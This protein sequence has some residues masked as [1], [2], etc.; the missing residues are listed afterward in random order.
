MLIY[1]SST[2]T[3]QKEFSSL[4]QNTDNDCIRLPGFS[5]RPVS[6]IEN[7]AFFSDLSFLKEAITQEK[8]LCGN[9][10]DFLLVFR[11][12]G[13]DY[14][15][16]LN[17]KNKKVDSEA[18]FT[19]LNPSD[20][21]DTRNCRRIFSREQNTICCPLFQAPEAIAE[22]RPFL[23]LFSDKASSP[24]D[25]Y[26]GNTWFKKELLIYSDSGFLRQYAEK[27]NVAEAMEQL[28]QICLDSEETRRFRPAADTDGAA[29]RAVF[30]ENRFC[31]TQNGTDCFPL[32]EQPENPEQYLLALS[33]MKNDLYRVFMLTDLW[34]GLPPFYAF[35]LVKFFSKQRAHCSNQLFYP[36]LTKENKNNSLQPYRI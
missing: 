28:E 20:L 14:L 15:Y 4:A 12:F 35:L 1:F 27:G 29:W 23:S 32:D 16:R 10:A 26:A 21:T 13:T 18:L 22:N 34:N 7:S 30:R 6:E 31:L 19:D 36:S 24:R 9:N 2:R 3:P 11:I 17:I 8:P 5:V 33:G 25:L